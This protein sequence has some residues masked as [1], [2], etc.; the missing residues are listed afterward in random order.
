MEGAEAYGMEMLDRAR[1]T[2]D[3]DDERFAERLLAE[4]DLL[5]GDPKRALDRLTPYLQQDRW[6]EDAGYMRTL[7]WAYLA[8]GR[9]SE[10]QD[11][12]AG[13]IARA[14]ALKDQP[15]LVEGLIMHGAILAQQGRWEAAR[16]HLDYAL[17]GA[18]RMPFPFGE[19]RALYQYGL[20]YR[21]K[22]DAVQA[23]DALAEA[24]ALFVGLGA[25]KDAELIERAMGDESE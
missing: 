1:G 10:A 13:A 5:N 11:A 24:L 9:E 2:D 6:R 17:S 3:L 8:N 14:T 25:F 20:M 12:A 22:G 19:A 15:E 21:Y 16:Q 18:R 4:H 7:A 23:D